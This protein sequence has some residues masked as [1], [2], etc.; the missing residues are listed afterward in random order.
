MYK[1]IV[2]SCDTYYYQLANDSDID[3]THAFMSTLGFGGLTGIDIEGEQAGRAALARVEAQ[4]L[5]G[6]EL[7]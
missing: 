7:P 6:Q 4:A 5:R 3:E 2:V 1:S